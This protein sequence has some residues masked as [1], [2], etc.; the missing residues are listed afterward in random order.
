MRFGERLAS[1]Y[2]LDDADLD[3]EAARDEIGRRIAVRGRVRGWQR[4]V[5][6]MIPVIAA[7]AVSVPVVQS[8]A[9]AGKPSL[10]IGTTPNA[11]DSPTATVQSVAL[12]AS[13]QFS[14]IVVT[15]SGLELEGLKASPTPTVAAICRQAPVNPQTL[16]LGPIRTSSCGGDPATATQTPSIVNSYLPDSNNATLRVAKPDPTTGKVNVGQV[17]MTYSHD[18]DSNPVVAY[19]DGLLWVYDSEST[20]GSVVLEVQA[21]TGYVARVVSA[22]QLARPVLAV[23]D[24]GL[25]IGNSYLGADGIAPLYLLKP[26]ADSVRVVTPTTALVVCWMVGDS[27]HLWVGMGLQYGCANQQIWRFDGD[28][29]QPTYH[30]AEAGYLPLTVIGGESEGLW[31]VVWPNPNKLETPQAREVISIDPNT[32]AESVAETLPPV[33]M[34]PP[35]ERGLNPGEAV[36]YQGSLYLLD[37]PASSGTSYTRLLKLP[38]PAARPPGG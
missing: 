7:L 2:R 21:A 13:D 29:T 17:V 11:P 18:S 25:W 28:Q 10:H 12:P 5:A 31:S 24:A 35:L 14:T 9:P 33:T 4:R 36:V 15:K 27:T 32:G 6:W 37:A 19:G 16:R 3:L 26:G 20:L 34:A 30:V 23:T 8:L 38:L 22:P 1:S